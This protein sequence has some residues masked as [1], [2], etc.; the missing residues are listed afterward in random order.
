MI[1]KDKQNNINI[2]KLSSNEK[3]QR[4]KMRKKVIRQSE[5]EKYREKYIQ[6]AEEQQ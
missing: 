1:F 6:K 4:E 3:N 2:T 5:I